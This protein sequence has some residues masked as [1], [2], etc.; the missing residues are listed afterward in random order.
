MSSRVAG[1]VIGGLYDS[2][3][4][5]C[6]IPNDSELHI[7]TSNFEILTIPGGL[8][9]ECSVYK[10][11]PTAYA[12]LATAVVAGSRNGE[13]NW[14][15]YV[16]YIAHDSNETDGMVQHSIGN[17]WANDDDYSVTL[18]GSAQAAI[19]Q[20][21]VQK[22]EFPVLT[23][24]KDFECIFE[25]LYAERMLGSVTVGNAK[26]L[27]PNEKISKETF[28]E[29]FEKTGKEAGACLSKMEIFFH[30]FI[31]V[32]VLRFIGF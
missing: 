16:A 11:E 23:C 10:L 8:K 20:V 25:E 14:K 1:S 3:K 32:L 26:L 22:E 18:D 19:G 31:G 21:V 12:E 27:E 29:T 9:K 28:E 5:T 4:K 17:V 13:L 24:V 30:T 15:N 7:E 6:A 2:S